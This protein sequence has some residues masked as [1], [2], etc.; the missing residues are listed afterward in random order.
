MSWVSPVTDCDKAP[1]VFNAVESEEGEHQHIICSRQVKSAC[2]LMMHVT[3]YSHTA[4]S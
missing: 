3:D 2:Q 1:C 4:A